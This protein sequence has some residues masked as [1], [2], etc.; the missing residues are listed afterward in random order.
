MQAEIKLEPF[1]FH[2]SVSDESERC[3]KGTNRQASVSTAFATE[4]LQTVSSVP[5]TRKKLGVEEAF[6]YLFL[7]N[8]VWQRREIPGLF[9]QNV[10]SLCSLNHYVN[11]SYYGFWDSKMTRISTGVD[12]IPVLHFCLILARRCFNSHRFALAAN[13]MKEFTAIKQSHV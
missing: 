1:L 11:R 6:F 5:I 7:E 9:D 3:R 2:N 10:N 4:F 8:T 12:K 13:V